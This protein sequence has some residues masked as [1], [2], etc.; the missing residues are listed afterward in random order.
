MKIYRIF[1][2]IWVLPLL[3]VSFASCTEDIMDDIN[4]NPNNPEDMES[5]F[6]IT[7]AMTKTAFSITG[8]DYNYYASVYIEH[9]VGTYGQMYNAEIRTAEPIAATTYNN[10]WESS[11]NV[12]LYLNTI[13]KKCSDGGEEAGNYH[14]L[15]IAQILLAY[16]MAVLTDLMGDVPWTEAAQPGVIYQPKLDKQEAIY[17]D[18]NTLLDNAIT[19]LSKTTNFASLGIQDMIYGGNAKKWIKAA[20]G[21]KARYAMRLSLRNPQY[22]NVINWADKSFASSA[23]ECKYAYN[24]SSAIS[25]SYKF[26]EDRSGN[27]SSSQSLFDK[28]DV[29]N[30]PR[31]DM[32]FAEPDNLAPNGNP[33]Q[34][35][36]KYGISALSSPTAPTFLMSYHELQF[37]KAEAYARLSQ[38]DEAKEALQEALSAAF[39]KVGLTAGAAVGY[40]QGLQTLLNA[41]LLKEIMVQKYLS[42]YEEESMEAYNDYRRLKAMNDDFISLANANNPAKFP[43]RYVYGASDVTANQNV[44][45]AYGDGSYVYTENVWWAGGTR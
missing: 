8:T 32:Y 23:D 22:Q 42:F 16:N 1:K 17:S 28:M 29:R 20:Y 6:I 19:N 39:E 45:A 15:G 41:N 12:V 3:V 2:K 7:D 31:I 9:N 33:V 21:L 11:Y 43:L 35:D 10:S 14:T 18:I 27:L 44:Y 30:D 38:P 34:S 13:I 40:Y 4:K 24:G 5:R 37:L 26:A 36:S 25:P